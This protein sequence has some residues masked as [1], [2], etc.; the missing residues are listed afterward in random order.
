MNR[1]PH[2]YVVRRD[3]VDYLD[4]AGDMV[5]QPDVYALAGFLAERC[6]ARWIVDIGCGAAGKLRRFAATYRLMCIDHAAALALARDSLGGATFVECDLEEGLA[7]IDEEILG[8]AV[9]ICADV[10]EHLRNP[11]VLARALARVSGMAPFVLISTP[12]RDRARG[13]LD[14]GPPANPSHVIEWSAAEFLRFLGDAGFGDLH[15][16]GHTVNTDLQRAKTTTLVVTGAHA[17][18]PAR[19]SGLRVAAVM[20]VFNEADILEEVVRH[21]FA[22]GIEV[23]IFDNWSSDGSWEIAGALLSA[24]LARLVERFP[25]APSGEYEWAR[26]LAKTEEYGA[27]LEADWVMHHDADEIRCSPWHG[28]RLVDAIA[29]ADGLGYDAI[30]FTVADF[31]FLR[32]RAQAAASFERALTFFEFGCRPGHYSQIKA[33]KNRCRVKLADSGGHAAAFPERRIYPLKFLTKHYPLRSFEQAQRKVFRDR[34]PRTR[35]EHATH[36]WHAQY[37]AFMEAGAI[38]GWLPQE[39]IAWHPQLFLTEY[40]VERISGIGLPGS[41]C[42]VP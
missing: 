1:L 37:D 10:M 7:V 6:G 17:A 14:C 24:G 28:V 18:R 3:H 26:L 39:L 27:G 31:R 2:G 21:L 9:V 19:H 33:W 40:V 16:H 29:A 4:V 34:I 22:E 20:H 42:D 5:Y 25:A 41:P 15:I 32:S 23:H 38:P 30:D 12:D 13:W 11:E 36:G 8:S 35:R